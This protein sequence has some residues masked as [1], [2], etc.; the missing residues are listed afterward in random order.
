MLVLLKVVVVNEALLETDLPLFREPL[1]VLVL[2]VLHE[3]VRIK[4]AVVE[5]LEAHYPALERI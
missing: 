5:V 3:H 4:H 2:L 1:K